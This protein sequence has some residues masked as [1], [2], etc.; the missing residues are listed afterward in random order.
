MNDFYAIFLILGQKGKILKFVSMN[1][2]TPSYKLCSMRE[3]VQYESGTSS[4]QAM[5]CN[6]NQ[7][8]HLHKWGCV[9]QASFGSKGH[10]FIRIHS[11]ECIIITLTNISSKNG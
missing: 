11:K 7:A 5:M 10:Y 2:V 3:D 8:H 1:T 6:T 9:V 4:V